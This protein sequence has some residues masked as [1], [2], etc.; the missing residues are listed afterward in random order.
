VAYQASLTQGFE[1]IQTKWLVPTTPIENKQWE[2]FSFVPQFVIDFVNTLPEHVADATA[3]LEQKQRQLFGKTRT[4]V[5]D[6]LN[7]LSDR[8][9]KDLRESRFFFWSRS[10]AGGRFVD[11]KIPVHTRFDGGGYFF[12][13]SSSGLAL[14]AGDGGPH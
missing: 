5:G 2:G 6:P 3:W 4:S 1:H 11:I 7:V 8:K 9:V 14:L 10:P 12:A 13:P